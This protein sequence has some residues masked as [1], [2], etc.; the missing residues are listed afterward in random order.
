MKKQKTD[1]YTTNKI[2]NKD[3]R[4]KLNKKYLIWL[5]AATKDFIKHVCT[6]ALPPV[7]RLYAAAA[8]TGALWKDCMQ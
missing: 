5:V 7:T 6:V 1:T 3:H 2:H 8:A 4:I